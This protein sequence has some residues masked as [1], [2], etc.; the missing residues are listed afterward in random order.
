MMDI[1]FLNNNS[2]SV[3]KTKPFCLFKKQTSKFL[4]NT[5]FKEYLNKKELLIIQPFN[6]PFYLILKM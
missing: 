5:L 1:V 2:F 4:K 3:L 6:H